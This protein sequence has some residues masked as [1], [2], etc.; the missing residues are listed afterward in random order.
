VLRRNRALLAAIAVLASLVLA[1]AGSGAGTLLAGATTIGGVHDS[2]SAGVAEAF[3]TTA[4]ASG[5]VQTITVYVDSSSVATSLTAGLYAD[6]NGH[7]GTLLTQGSLASPAKGAWDD[8]PV[9]D[10]GVTSGA[11]YWIAIL[12]PRGA[13]TVQFRDVHGGSSETSA[14]STLSALP[15]TWATGVRYAD[16]P[17][18]A[19]ASGGTSTVPTLEVTP[20]SISFAANAGGSD[21]GGAQVTVSNGGSGTL[22][23]TAAS[24]SPWLTVSP[25]SG[26]APVTL[27]VSASVAGL[28]PATYTGHVTVTA[29]GASGSP[30]TITVTFV[31][32]PQAPP[33]SADWTQVDRDVARTGDA[34]G[35]T[36]ITTANASTLAPLWSQ[37]VDGKVTA[38]PLFL[39]GVTVAGGVHDV[40]IAATN[41][42]SVYALDADTGATLWRRNFGAEDGNCAIPGGF[43]VTG[44]PAVDKANGRVY[45]VSDGGTLYTMS[46]ADGSDA[47]APLQ[48]VTNPDTNKVW[49]G[50]SLTGG[51][52]YVSTASDGCDTPPWRGEVFHLGVGGS[53]PQLLGTWVVVPSIAAPN[54]GGGVWGYGGVAVDPVTGNVYAATAADSNE[55]YTLWADRMV[56]LSGAL[57]VLGSYGPSEPTNFPCSGSPCDLD[58]G[59][60]PV[61]YQPSGC[62]TMAAAG[63]K[64]GNLYVFQAGDLAASGA[65]AQVLTLNTPNDSLGSGGVGGNPAYW[66]A[67]RMLFVGDAGSGVTG[68][69]AGLVGLSVASDCTLSVAW[70]LS[71]GGGGLPNSTPTVANGV[72][73]I[74]VGSG[75]AVDAVDAATGSVLWS[76]GSFGSGSTFA[77]PIVAD[78]RLFVGSWNG[79]SASATGTIRAYA[80]SV[81]DTT[82][83]SVSLTAPADGSTV[84]GTVAVVASASDNVGVVGVQF[85]LDGVALGAEDLV[86]PYSVSWDS[87]T[88][89]AGSHVLTA[90][91][92]DAAGNSTT[93]AAVSVTV[94]NGPPP[95]PPTSVLLGD[96][97]IESVNDS[98][99]AGRAEAFKT[100]AAL[101]GTLTQLTVYVAPGSTATSL[102]V[103]LYT[104]LGGHP[105]TLLTQG[106]LA[107][108]GKGAWVDVA[109]P[110][111]AV[112]AGATYWIA[113]LAPTGGG[114]LAFRDTHGGNSETS[115]SGSLTS[116]PGTW[117][118]GT[119]YGDGPLSA[120]GSGS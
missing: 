84:S 67:G 64:N 73:F 100:S 74:G 29:P 77:A 99:T 20:T 34:V 76:S 8:V 21:P 46:L 104:D 56:A 57:Q 30:A 75:G 40:V 38:Q 47:A 17:L 6:A 85:R 12:S 114:T 48:L 3:R 1:G 36:T 44:A 28:S 50:L 45:A 105:G 4:V 52:L 22:S 14:S 83:P 94:D 62:P 49:G 63:N 68:V 24:D 39:K 15:A 103:G 5:T 86:A 32:S 26:N 112:T 60:T 35:E 90:V 19:Y 120:Y 37:A 69:S 91:A 108:P 13:G 115:A 25:G 97:K 66:S 18:S 72:V 101:S 96:Q 82:P 65:P 81:P 79:F 55:G 111:A 93:S 51:D 95:P 107:A 116:L 11:T 110:G 113:V 58:F 27:S 118:T 119:R 106:T 78:G 16:G 71:L 7:P 42:N 87:T 43:G 33:A 109:V 2:D 102:V 117:S 61:V 80:P 53:A 23:F 31:V 70:S 92:R 88:A 10:V 41:A 89:S 54:G 9:P 98:N 59:A